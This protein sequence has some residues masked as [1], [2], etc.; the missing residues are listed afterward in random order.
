ME[1]QRSAWAEASRNTYG[2]IYWSLTVVLT[3]ATIAAWLWGDES[4]QFVMS[5]VAIVFVFVFGAIHHIRMN[6]IAR[7]REE[8]LRD[9][10]ERDAG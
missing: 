2:R 5:A 9:E 8:R 1:K 3:L 10:P 4:T 7:E 6:R